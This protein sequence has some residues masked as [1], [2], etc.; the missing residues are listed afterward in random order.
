MQPAVR[1]Y[2]YDLNG[3]SSDD[4]IE[5]CAFQAQ[6]VATVGRAET[7]EMS[8]TAEQDE[9]VE[10]VVSRAGGTDDT[11]RSLET[12]SQ[13]E[14][15]EISDT[16]EISETAEIH[17]TAGSM[18]PFVTAMLEVYET[19]EQYETVEIAETDETAELMEA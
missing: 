10:I 5:L 13:F 2:K 16:V 17:E 4:E 1:K 3:D 9:T 11:P 6:T 8:E 15:A 18:G 14:T 7:A 12:A 19:A